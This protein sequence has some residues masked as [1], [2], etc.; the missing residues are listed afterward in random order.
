MDSP[1]YICLCKAVTDHDIEA[2][3]FAGANTLGQVQRELAVS[4]G[5]GRCANAAQMVVD[6]AVAKRASTD[7]LGT[8]GLGIA[9]LATQDVAALVYAA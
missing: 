9:N 7:T 6:Q 5:C 8:T 4:T 3:V 2:A 1:V